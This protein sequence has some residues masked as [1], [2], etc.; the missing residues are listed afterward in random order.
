MLY[1]Y[2]VMVA[3]SPNEEPQSTTISPVQANTDEQIATVLARKIAT[4]RTAYKA[5]QALP[6]DEYEAF[7]L[8][9]SPVENLSTL[10][11]RKEIVLYSAV[12]RGLKAVPRQR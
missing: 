10:P 4:L 12:P 2:G 7:M 1:G 9:V 11:S 6:T 3:D 5:T 8:I